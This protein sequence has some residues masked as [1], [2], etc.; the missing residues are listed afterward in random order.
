MNKKRILVVDDEKDMVYAVKLQLE[1]NAYDVL[2]A[3]DGQ[4]A[5]DK[6]HREKPDLIILDVMLP[7]VDGYK[8]CRMLKFDKKYKKIP[9]LMFTA[10][11]TKNDE[12]IGFEVGADAYIT[13]PFEPPMLLAKI[14]ELLK[15]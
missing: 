11:V 10:R 6:A 4:E 1:A 8:V 7:K 2:T 3:Q 13:K 14:K 15:D 5:L 9:I 12:K